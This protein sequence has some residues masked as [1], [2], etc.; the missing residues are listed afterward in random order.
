MANLL[1]AFLYIGLICFVVVVI[2]V[3]LLIKA[4]RKS[5]LMK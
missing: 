2:Q 4:L 1:T 3:I 5:R